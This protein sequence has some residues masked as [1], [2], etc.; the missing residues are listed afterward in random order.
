MRRRPPWQLPRLAGLHTLF[1]LD[2]L[3]APSRE[4]NTFHSC[5]GLR[6]NQS[7]SKTNSYY[8]Y[9]FDKMAIQ[10]IHNVSLISVD[11]TLLHHKVNSISG[12]VSTPTVRTGT[13]L[14]K[15]FNCG[16]KALSNAECS[17]K[18]LANCQ[19]PNQP[20]AALILCRLVSVLTRPSDWQQLYVRDRV[21]NSI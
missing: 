3:Y 7:K 18:C 19:T 11:F 1:L 17:S 5:H 10:L 14:S 16:C 20:R 13:C 12:C 2:P 15:Q 8:A 4:K 21:V 9:L 6:T